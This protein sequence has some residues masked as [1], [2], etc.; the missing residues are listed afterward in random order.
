MTDHNKKGWPWPGTWKVVCDV[1]GV[2]HP[3]SRVKKRW[4]GLMVCEKDWEPRHPQTLYRYHPHT[5]VPDFIRPE[6]PNQFVQFCDIFSSSGF[7]DMATADC[8]RADQASPSYETLVDLTTNGHE[9]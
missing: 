7:A 3:S 5:S 6:P 4:D 1:C 9:S 8:A 2:Q